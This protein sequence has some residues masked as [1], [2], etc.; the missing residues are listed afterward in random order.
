MHP[1]VIYFPDRKQ[2]GYMAGD[3]FIGVDCPEGFELDE[4]AWAKNGKNGG[5]PLR[6][7]APPKPA[8]AVEPAKAAEPAP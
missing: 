7:V 3:V 6:L 8:K 4:S 1:E 2:N 5:A